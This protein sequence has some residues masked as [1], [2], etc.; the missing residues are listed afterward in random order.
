MSVDNPIN[1]DGGYNAINQEGLE[2]LKIDM[3]INIE[4]KNNC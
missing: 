1:R 2:D 3:Q 4:K